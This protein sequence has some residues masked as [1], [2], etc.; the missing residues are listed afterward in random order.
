M[1]Y[2]II[3]E[4]TAGKVENVVNALLEQDWRLKG[5]LIVTA[6]FMTDGY[7]KETQTQWTY[8]QVMIKQAPILQQPVPSS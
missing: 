7:T 3:E 8:T 6:L 4:E 2:H 1:M 5:D